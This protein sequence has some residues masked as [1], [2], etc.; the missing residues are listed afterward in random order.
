[1]HTNYNMNQLTLDISTSYIPKKDST[2]W[3]INELVEAL[4]INEPYLF[5]RPRSYDLSAMLKLVLFAYTRSVFSSRKIEQLAEESLPARW[6]TQEQLPTYRTIARFRISNDLEGL[7]EKGL[8]VLV[9]YLRERQLIDDAIFIDGTK[10]LADANKYSFVWKRS[11][12][13]YDKMNRDQLLILISEL[14]EAH[15]ANH[16]PEGTT[17]TLDMLDEVLTRMELRL[18]EL[19][20]EVNETKKV[21]PN[22]AKQQRRKLKSQKRKLTERRDKLADHQKRLSTCGA[23]N[24]YS[25]TDKDATFMRVKEDPMKNG[26]LKPAY[27]LQIGTSNQF[28]LAYDVYQNPTDTKTLPSFLEKIAMKE[29]LPTYIVADAG[30]GSE[31]NYRFLEDEL[32][33]HTALIPYGTM[34]KEQSKKWKSDERKVMNW[35]YH[36]KD[37]YYIDP[38]GV[39]F[40]FNAYR[41]ETDKKDGFIREFKEYK[42]EKYTENREVI[43]EA[44]TKKGNVRIIKV[45]PALEYFK[46]KQRTLLSESKTGE[47]YGQRKIDVEPVFGWMKA[48]LHFTRY[49]VRG[50][51]KVKKETGILVMAL[52]MRKL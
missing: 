15:L 6:L 7:I 10:I 35:T 51:E 14:K 20:Q 26:Q 18:E 42:A 44:L 12:I 25:K 33:E 11:T 28:V 9:G 41:T 13:K 31:Q 47:I 52:N 19:E 2:A 17:L 3:F 32:S 27:N 23:R 40:N 4:E 29:F 38:K 34:L 46:A 39:R 49:H 50:L 30:Y 37:D 43:Q 22:P 36:E 24:S 8:D 16:I 5:G 21:S 1:M 45:N 48:C